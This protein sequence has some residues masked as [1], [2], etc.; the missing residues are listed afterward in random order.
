[1]VEALE[2]EAA[3]QLCVHKDRGFSLFKAVRVDGLQLVVAGREFIDAEMIA[4]EPKP[5]VLVNLAE[6]DGLFV[7]VVG[8]V[9][10]L[11]EVPRDIDRRLVHL[12]LELQLVRLGHEV[13]QHVNGISVH[14][15]F[16]HTLFL[17]SGV[18]LLFDDLG[19]PLVQEGR[20]VVSL[21]DH[22]IEGLSLLLDQQLV[23]A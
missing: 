11:E 23:G 8:Q 3:V 5:V 7:T 21:P 15:E 22:N 10:R 13:L 16:F 14:V 6:P 18:L 1:M 2:A 17:K 4:I 12:L 19:H 9:L 20:V